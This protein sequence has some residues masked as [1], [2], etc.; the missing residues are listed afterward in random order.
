MRNKPMTENKT[1]QIRFKDFSDEWEEK[2]LGE[3]AEFSKGKGYSKGE[4][5]E[6]GTPVIL[7]GRLYTKYETE[8]KNVDTFVSKKKDSVYSKGNEVIVPAS[9]ETAEDIARASAVLQKGILLGGDINIISPHKE[10]NSTFLALNITNGKSHSELAKKAQGKSIVHIHNAE[11]QSLKLLIPSLAEQQ[12]IGQFFCTLDNLI[13]AVNT[14]LCSLQGTKKYFL[15]KMFPKQ[16]ETVPQIRFKGFSDEWQEKK[17]GEIAEIVGGGTPSTNKSEYWNGDIDWY[18]P[19]EIM[20][21]IYVDS[22]ERKITLKGFNSSSAKMLP[23]G[24]VLFT[25][26]AGIGKT[27]ILNKE[28]CTN[29]GFQSIVPHKDELDSYFIFS[30][31]A[32][33][34][35]YGETVG[36]GSTFV[37]VSGKQMAEMKLSIPSLAE[38]QKIGQFFKTL[39]DS[40]SC[41][42]QKLDQLKTLKKAMLQKMFV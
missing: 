38:Q 27:A 41:Q 15:Q 34:K 6:Q 20:D 37:E 8:I 18:A 12:K 3:I 31:T 42:K 24:T 28:A 36:A 13:K 7:Y 33:L 11:I 16:G 35:K 5:T 17:L 29:Q 40:I 2:K 22:S 14:K 26:R 1:P 23:I 25:S 21:Q 4:L 30:R 9:G 39:D 10:L 32:E 19:A